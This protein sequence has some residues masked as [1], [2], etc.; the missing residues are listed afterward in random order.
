MLSVY[1][2]FSS[3]FDSKLQYLL[4]RLFHSFASCGTGE[5]NGFQGGIYSFKSLS[6]LNRARLLRTSNTNCVKIR[7]VQVTCA[8]SPIRIFRLSF[9]SLAKLQ[10]YFFCYVLTSKIFNLFP[11]KQTRFQFLRDWNEELLE[12]P[13]SS[14]LNGRQQ[15]I[16]RHIKTQWNI[17][18]HI[19]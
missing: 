13:S 6:C 3:S 2:A 1:L 17:A 15:H 10:I 16:A 19:G 12:E 9:S 7:V 8:K 4:C 18:I 14:V 11:L 5:S